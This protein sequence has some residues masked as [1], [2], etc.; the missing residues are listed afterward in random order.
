MV[1]WDDLGFPTN[2]SVDADLE[3]PGN[4]V[5]GFAEHRI[6]D[7]DNGILGAPQALVRPVG[8]E[9][10]LLV[11]EFGTL[12]ALYATAD[13]DVICVF[14]QLRR[15]VFVDVANPTRQT[16]AIGI[17]PVR[18]AASNDQGLLLVCDWAGIAAFGAE[19]V[20]WRA[21]ELVADL[22]VTRAD[23]DRIYYRGAGE[24]RGVLDARTGA[25]IPSSG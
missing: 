2:Y 22:H 11:T 19:G 4:G 8:A 15:L 12:G 17:A 9:P 6:L 10:W 14:D 18:M 25:I 3:Y 16:L 13:P 5:W 1:F 7:P 21:T 20:R 24:T 23:G